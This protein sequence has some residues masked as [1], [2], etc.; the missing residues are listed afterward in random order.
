[1]QRILQIVDNLSMDSGVSA[2]LMNLYRNISKEDIQFDFL[3]C[4]RVENSYEREIEALGGSVYYMGNPLSA[5]ECIKAN[6]NFK[7]FF[8]RRSQDYAVVHLHSPTISIFS[9]RY[10]KRYKVANRIVHSHSSMTSQNKFKALI[11]LFLMNRGKAYANHYWTCSTK[12]AR[13]L[14]GDRCCNH[15]SI[16]L[17]KNAVDVS[18]FR[19]N[20]LLADQC[21]QEL[22]CLPKTIVCHVSN[23][24][25]IKNHIFLIDVM[26]RAVSC[27]K[28]LVFLYVGDGPVRKRFETRVKEEGL[29]QFCIFVGKTDRVEYYL[30]GADFV[31]LP[32]IKE[33]LPVTIVEAQACG[34]PCL[35]SDT[36]TA[37]VDVGQVAFLSLQT[38][39]W[40]QQL[41]ALRRQSAEE[42]ERRSRAFEN[43]AFNI[44]NEAKRVEQLY[45][46]LGETSIERNLS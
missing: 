20:K 12:A 19:Y 4:K 38:S 9:L 28:D 44:M 7:M 1:M 15:H 5:R 21:R 35:V 22:A 39:V 17:I 45:R 18:K 42:R 8:Q 11:N 13:F 2:M 27:R 29:S 41:V 14:F 16:N 46:A 26:K 43:T 24:H 23:F 30:Q 33:G 10:A 34:V 25:P 6:R 36:V 31:W 3:V 40:V 37:E 32:S